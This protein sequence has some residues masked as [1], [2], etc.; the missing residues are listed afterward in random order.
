MNQGRLMPD[1]VV[2][3]TDLNQ[4]PTGLGFRVGLGLF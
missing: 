2:S 1:L 4:N 3:M